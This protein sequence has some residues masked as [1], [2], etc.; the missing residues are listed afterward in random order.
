MKETMPAAPALVRGVVFDLNGTLVDD[1]CFHRGAWHAL[2]KE[3]G[4]AMDEARFQSF[5]GLKNVDIM[6]RLLGRDVTAEEVARLG[7]RKEAAYRA[8][9]RPHLAL[10]PGA[11]ALLSR[12]RAASVPVAIASSAPPENRAMVIDGLG[13]DAYV[14][15]V[16]AAEHLPGKPA[17]DVFLEAARQLGVT[18]TDCLAFEDAANGVRA[19]ASAGMLVGAV[20]TNNPAEVLLEAGAA[21]AV[22]DFTLL[23]SEIDARLPR[24][25]L[26]PG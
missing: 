7:E 21:F 18:P 23:P 12:L 2:A 9:Y 3:L 17:P 16:V 15:V 1:I 19:A 20:T 13:L 10:V 8:M 22:A 14:E 11:L 6:P 24:A 26:R 4:L 5:N 25:A